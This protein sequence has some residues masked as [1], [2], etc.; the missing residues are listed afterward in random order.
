MTGVPEE[1]ID[2][3][4]DEKYMEDLIVPGLVELLATC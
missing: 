3:L 1:Y 4:L 2:S